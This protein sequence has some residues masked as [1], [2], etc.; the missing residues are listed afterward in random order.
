MAASSDGRT[1]YV[2]S[3]ISDSLSFWASKD[4][5][6][7]CIEG[8]YQSMSG[9]S[10]CIGCSGGTYQALAGQSS[11]SECPLGTFQNKTFQIEEES[12]IECKAGTYQ[13]E[14]GQSSCKGCCASVL[15]PGNGNGFSLI[16]LVFCQSVV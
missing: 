3:E 11:C 7:S 2:A 12:C 10:E 13:D 4:T 15:V 1:I 6:L 8:T 14:L 5:C 9:A 16:S